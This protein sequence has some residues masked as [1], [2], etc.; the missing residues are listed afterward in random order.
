M[1]F[2]SILTLI[3]SVLVHLQ[4]IY[5]VSPEGGVT[6][7]PP[8]HNGKRNETVRFICVSEGGPR[9]TFT[10][11]RILDGEV[12]V[13]S[14]FLEVNVS[15]ADSGGLYECGV[16]NRAGSGSVQAVLN[17]MQGLLL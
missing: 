3:E 8:V 5:T 9:N 14:S 17:G 10:W 13:N 6:S 15:G 1:Y 2:Q 11:T 16:G 4:L 7:A 12:L